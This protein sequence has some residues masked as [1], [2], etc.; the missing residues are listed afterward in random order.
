MTVESEIFMF[1][2]TF[3]AIFF[4]WVFV[5]SQDESPHYCEV[6]QLDDT[7]KVSTATEPGDVAESSRDSSTPPPVPPQTELSLRYMHVCMTDQVYH[8][9]LNSCPSACE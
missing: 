8:T 7:T 3:L 4:F 5:L 2:K 9:N 1:G 6:R